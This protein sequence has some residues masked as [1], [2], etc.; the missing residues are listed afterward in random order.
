MRIAI[1]AD[2]GGFE[3]KNKIFDYLSKLEDVEVSDFGTYSTDSVDY[4][5]I[6]FMVSIEV[7]KGNYDY[8]ILID[9]IG[10]G[11]AMAAGKV[12]GIL[13]A[14]CND[15]T[16]SKAAREHDNANVLVMGSGIVGLLLAKE[17]VNDFI[18]TP[19]GGGRHER[20][21][22][23]ILKFEDANNKVE[24][25]K[26]TEKPKKILTKDDI[27]SV[28]RSGGSVVYIEK[29]AIITPLAKEFADE[30]KVRIIKR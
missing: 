26:F 16:T 27:S 8:G 10:I 6:A 7:A 3:L 12:K 21:I 30:K 4:P 1:G 22:N 28:I 5:D 11:S 2:H 23:K 24:I 9:G 20:R 29:N 14:T 19:F 15:V 25:D 18:R 13:P 17:I